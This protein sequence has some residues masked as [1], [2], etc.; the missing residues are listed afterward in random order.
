[1]KKLLTSLLILL[2][3]LTG[4][5][6]GSGEE[7]PEGSKEL[8]VY[9]LSG[10][11]GE[12]GWNKVV[13]AF[14][15]KYGIEVNLVLE[16]NIGEV[17][18]PMIQA[19]EIPDV[20]YLAV[21]STDPLTDTM[22]SEK[23]IEDI[24]D[25]LDK[26]VSDEGVTVKEKVIDG[27]FNSNR[28]SP[29]GDGNVYLTPLFYSPLGLFYNKGIFA[30]KGW[31]LP[32]TWDEMFALGDEAAELGIALFTYPTAGYFDGFFSSLLN[33]VVGPDMYNKLM[34]YDVDAWN[35]PKTKE[36]FEIVGKLADYTHPNTVAQANSEG[37]QKNQQLVMENE[38]LFVPNGTW[39]P[40]E[41]KEAG[42]VAVDGFEWGLAPI[43]ASSTG[44]DLYSSTFTEEAYIPKGAKNI[45]NAKLFLAYLYSDEAAKLF[46]DNGG[47][48]QPIVGSENLIP[49]GDEKL[50]YYNIYSDGVKS[51]T[52]GFGATEPVEGVNI[53]DILYENVNS[54]VNGDKTVDEWY[55][56]VVEAIALFN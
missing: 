17:L 39:L 11:Y 7:T 28:V 2:L 32:Q 42:V 21:G 55:N 34:D 29:Y 25:L 33:A 9:G 43:P 46:Y 15:E 44:G 16:Q 24:S 19:E 49:E 35:D 30:E 48:V 13:A 47:A 12:E 36:A 6:G 41:M 52:V 50:I 1:M 27:F 38:A 10:G 37:F 3:V 14:S 22:I 20:I 8:T 51:N 53:F 31:D 40:G 26:E 23:A 18:R 54:V 5:A 56:E 45:D 4:C